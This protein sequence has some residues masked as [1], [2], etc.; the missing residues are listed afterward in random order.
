LLALAGKPVYSVGPA[1]DDR[2]VEV[3]LGDGTRLQ[4]SQA[5]VVTA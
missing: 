5:E 2:W 1:G 4:A 3:V